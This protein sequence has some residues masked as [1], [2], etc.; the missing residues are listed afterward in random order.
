MIELGGYDE[1]ERFFRARLNY[2]TGACEE[3]E[4]LFNQSLILYQKTL[5]TAYSFVALAKIDPGQ[6]YLDR[7]RPAEAPLH[8]AFRIRQTLYGD[9]HVR[10]AEVKQTLGVCLTA[11]VHYNE[12]EPLLQASLALHQDQQRSESTRQIRQALVNLYLAWSKPAQAAHYRI[13]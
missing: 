3:A 1:A 7:N 8:D 13:R 2:E 6:L 10:T 12:A 11:L 4:Q 5:P 9:H